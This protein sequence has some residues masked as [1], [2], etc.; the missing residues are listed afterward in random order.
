MKPLAREIRQRLTVL[1]SALPI[2]AEVA[3]EVVRALAQAKGCAEALS[4]P[5]APLEGLKNKPPVGPGST[6]ESAPSPDN[7]KARMP[8]WQEDGDRILFICRSV[9]FRTVELDPYLNPRAR[10]K[11]DASQLLRLKSRIERLG[12]VEI[13]DFAREN[14][15]YI[16]A[17][18]K[19]S[20]GTAIDLALL[21]LHNNC[22]TSADILDEFEQALQSAR[23]HINEVADLEPRLDE[24]DSSEPPPPISLELY[25]ELQVL[26]VRLNR[27]FVPVFKKYKEEWARLMAW[28]A[29]SPHKLKFKADEEMF[30]W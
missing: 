25:T 21:L 19:G 7:E 1:V 12:A 9:H 29:F 27:L 13:E 14:Q 16:L 11:S 2:A 8:D 6:Q 17:K 20:L 24:Y 4:L 23:G 10:V 3:D 26:E 22:L 18:T 5:K 30:R 15:K 28:A